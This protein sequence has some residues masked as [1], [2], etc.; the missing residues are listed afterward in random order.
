M[1]K[2]TYAKEKVSCLLKTDLTR[3]KSGRLS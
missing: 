2:E 3:R 1:Y